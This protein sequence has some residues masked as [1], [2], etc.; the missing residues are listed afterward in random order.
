MCRVD[1]LWWR[2]L[3]KVDLGMAY[4]PIMSNHGLSHLQPI[5]LTIFPTWSPGSLPS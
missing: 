5:M 4:P 1:R 3:L 2:T